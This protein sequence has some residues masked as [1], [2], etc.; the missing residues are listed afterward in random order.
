MQVSI[1]TACSSAL[2]A[3]HSAVQNLLKHG[4]SALAGAVNT[5]LAESTTAAAF[6]AG[7]LTSDGRCKTLD[8]TADGYVRAEGCIALRLDSD[9]DGNVGTGAILAGTFVNQVRLLG[10]LPL[11]CHRQLGFFATAT[12]QSCK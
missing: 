2:V 7:M 11:P 6:T 4:G 12:S 1:D 5:M 10:N 8:A 3:I 9:L